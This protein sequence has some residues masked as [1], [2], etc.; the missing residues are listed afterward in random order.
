MSSPSFTLKDL[1]LAV[2]RSLLPPEKARAALL[3][4][5]GWIDVLLTTDS[6]VERIRVYK[7]L[8]RRLVWGYGNMQSLVVW[9]KIA[10]RL[11]DRAVPHEYYNEQF[12]AEQH[13]AMKKDSTSS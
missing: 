9:S 4:I 12:R 6:D 13:A 8:L 7:K 10:Q 5:R 3:E 2:S 1:E 11:R